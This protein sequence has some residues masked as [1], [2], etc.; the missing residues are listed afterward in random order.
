MIGFSE[1]SIAAP[2]LRRYSRTTGLSWWE[3]VKGTPGSS[4]SS[5]SPSR[6]SCAGLTTDQSRQ[7]ATASTWREARRWISPS[8]SASSSA[9]TTEP[10]APIRSG[11]SKVSR[12]GT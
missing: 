9:R 3:R 5:S 4:A 12:R 6:S 7:T 1:A 11:T 8:V 2:E 10:S